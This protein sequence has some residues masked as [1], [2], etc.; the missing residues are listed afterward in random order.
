MEAANL[1]WSLALGFLMVTGLR[2][3]WGAAWTGRGP[4]LAIGLAVLTG[5]GGGA[6]ETSSV[7]AVMA[8]GE[9][10]LAFPVQAVARMLYMAGSAALFVGVWRVFHPD[11]VWAR[12]LAVTGVTA[13]LA[14]G[15]AWVSVGLHSEVRGADP[16]TLL[17]HVARA[18]S[19]VW[20]GIA[21]FRHW[22][23]LRRRWRV[24]LVEHVIAQ[25][26]FL[27]GLASLATVA[28]IALIAAN[29]ILLGASPLASQQGVTLLALLGLLAGT[30]IYSAF[31]PPLLY[32]RW[33][34]LRTA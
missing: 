25:Q 10:A 3:L 34:T 8:G 23:R 29:H 19:Y 12:T 31:F 24:G 6:L 1:A 14:V 26:F 9:A 5:A 13:S 11:R 7:R 30:T 27:W 20:G 15:I 33:M 17:F 2:L 18:S 16:G 22:N 32:R 21:S 4:E 28:L